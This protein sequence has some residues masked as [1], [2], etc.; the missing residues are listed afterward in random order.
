MLLD[1]SEPIVPF[2]GFEEIK[3]YSTR[4]ELREL[5]EKEGVESEIMLV[6]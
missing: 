6:A 3:L 1:I 5:L 2:G 4:D